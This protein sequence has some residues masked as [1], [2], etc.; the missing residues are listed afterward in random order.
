[1]VHF[2][3]PIPEVRRQIEALCRAVETDDYL[4]RI[5][6]VVKRMRTGGFFFHAKDD[7]P[8]V[9]ERLFK[10]IRTTDCSLEMAVGRKIPALFNR[11]HHGQDSEFYAELLSPLLINKLKPGQRHVINSAERGKTTRNHVLQ[12]ATTMARERFARQQDGAESKAEVAFNVQNPRSEPLLCVPDY[13]AWTVQ[14]V[15]ERGETRHDD[16]MR[17]RIAL[18][19]DLY[20]GDKAG[21]FGNY[22]TPKNR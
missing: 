17:Q 8:E 14:R 19:I 11:Q 18:V 1:M 21:D 22:Y 15:F 10:W 20:P 2:A 3:A 13:L 6:S 9:R 7:C 12:L 16:F 4:N 5:P